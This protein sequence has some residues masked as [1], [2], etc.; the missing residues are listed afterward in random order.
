VCIAESAAQ[1]CVIYNDTVRILNQEAQQVESSTRFTMK[2]TI[3]N[4]ARDKTIETGRIIGALQG[5]QPGPLLVFCGGIHG[6]E[7]AGLFALPQVYHKLLESDCDF[8]GKSV[9]IAGNVW[10]LSQPKRYATYDL[11]RLW[12]PEGIE[13]L[14]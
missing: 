3:Y 1:A 12:T 9:A 14:K 5:T 7:P 11:N 8:H 10:A 6:N 13:Q 4:N 2:K